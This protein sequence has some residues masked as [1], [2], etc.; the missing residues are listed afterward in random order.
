MEAIGTVKDGSTGKYAQGYWT[1]GA[2]ILSPN[3]SQPIPIY[4][5]LYPCKKQGGDGLN[6]EIKRCL[7]FLRDM[8][9]S[10]D[11]PRVYDRG[12][13]SG[14]IFENLHSHSEKFIMRQNH[15]RNGIWNGKRVKINDIANRIECCHEMEYTGKNSKTAVCKIGITTVVIPRF[16]GIELRN[17]KVN[18]VVCKEWGEEPLILYTNLDESLE[19]IALRVIKA[20]L[21][22]W[23]I[24]ELYALKKQKLNFEEFRVRSLQAI[25]SL[26]TIITCL[27]GFIALQAD[28]V[29]YDDF[30]LSLIAASKRMSKLN[31]FLKETKFF[32][33][34]VLDGMAEVLSSLKFGILGYAKPPKVYDGQLSLF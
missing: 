12:G 34:A 26:D 10:A 17:F 11:I 8:D 31:K 25:K 33:Y 29:E 28:K 5:E 14:M 27:L 1:M 20:Y 9:F 19:R 30:T 6:V 24:E 18:L 23:R 2:V 21:K 13:D 16:N 22:R 32:L 4:E 3:N 15:N 7:Q